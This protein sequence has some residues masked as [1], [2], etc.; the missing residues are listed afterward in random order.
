MIPTY[1]SRRSSASS[2][3]SLA[4][5]IGSVPFLEGG[6]EHRVPFQALGSVVGQQL[7]PGR[8]ATGLDGRSPGDLGEEGRDVRART[9]PEEVVGKLEQSDDRAVALTCRLAIRDDVAPHTELARECRLQ[10]LGQ[11]RVALGATEAFGN[12]DGPTDLRPG[13]E[14]LTTDVERDAGDAHRALD[15]GQL[16]I[17]PDEDG[18]RAVRR[19]RRSERPDGGSHPGEFGLIGR[20]ATDLRRRTR[21]QA[22][23]ESL[24][25]SR[26][27]PGLAFVVDVR[28]AAR[29]RLA[30]PRISG[31]ER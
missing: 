13:E 12:T 15:G 8:L 27:S 31:V 28:P 5:R 26:C 1:S 19:A 2:A 11:R 16:G 6:Q 3:G 22:R 4:W 21:R 10:A 25:R 7:D 30:R 29:T 20:E 17:G 14:P 9:R 23:D 24:G 18:H